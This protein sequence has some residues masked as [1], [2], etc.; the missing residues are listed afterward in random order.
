MVVLFVVQG[1]L[2]EDVVLEMEVSLE[3]EARG[4]DGNV[5]FVFLHW[6]AIANTQQ[7]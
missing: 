6:Q 1:D 7:G 5:G 3:V 2:T 4:E